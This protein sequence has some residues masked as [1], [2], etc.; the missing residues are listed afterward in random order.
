MIENRAEQK[1]TPNRLRKTI[2]F[3]FGQDDPSEDTDWLFETGRIEQL[4]KEERTPLRI[5]SIGSPGKEMQAYYQI[6]PKGFEPEDIKEVYQSMGCFVFVHKLGK[7]RIGSTFTLSDE[8]VEELN[9]RI[10]SVKENQQ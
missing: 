2:E 4:V 7:Q 8:Q 9:S 6:P 10:A 1:S 5:G 3:L